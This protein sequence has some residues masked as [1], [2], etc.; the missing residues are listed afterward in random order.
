M[1]DDNSTAAGGCERYGNA[2]DAD[3]D[4]LMEDVLSRN[5]KKIHKVCSQNVV[6]LLQFKGV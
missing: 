6:R 3:I 2:D 4:E 1:S 5:R